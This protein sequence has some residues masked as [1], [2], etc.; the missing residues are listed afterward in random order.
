[1]SGLIKEDVDLNRIRIFK[2]V[3]EIGSFSKAAIRLNV[4]KSNVS[5]N[6]SLLE[7]QLGT[8]LIY[9]TTRNLQLTEAGKELYS[10]SREVLLKLEDTISKVTATRTEIS[11]LIRFSAPTDLGVLT[12]P[13]LAN[14]L[15]LYP[16]VRIETK[17]TNSMLDLVKEGID[18]AIRAGRLK[19]TSLLARKVAEVRF[20]LVA[21]PIFL[22][23]F[24]K[25]I[26]VTNL[27]KIPSISSSQMGEAREWKLISDK[28]KINVAIDPV[29]SADTV[30]MVRDLAIQGVGVA[31]LP[32]V[33]CKNELQS[34]K[35]IRILPDWSLS[36]IPVH[37]I[38][39][40]QKEKAQRVKVFVDVLVESL[41]TL[42]E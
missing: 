41:R 36:T 21:S 6:I 18:V 7:S 28:K 17:L 4:P 37:I 5:R 42:L 39:P 14:F 10:G 13:C 31:A 15:K 30:A 35:L 26:S 38:T 24:S 9:R 32:L 12:V 16:Q 20:G 11:G 8:Q 2:L 22:D 40:S 34:G 19:D 27:S 29:C 33:Y 25:L 1:M 3:V 23:R